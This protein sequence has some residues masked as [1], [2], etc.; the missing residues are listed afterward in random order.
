MSWEEAG[1][2]KASSIRL[3]ILKL[4][5]NRILTP[6][7]LSEQLHK[8]LSQISKSLKQLEE[9]NVIACKTPRLKKGRLYGITSKGKELLDRI[10]GLQN[11]QLPR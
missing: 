6:K 4:L 8:H 2:I 7:D 11:E 5:L 9:M 1:T 3:E 10:E